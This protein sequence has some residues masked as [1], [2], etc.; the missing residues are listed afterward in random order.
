MKK[1]SRTKKI[2]FKINTFLNNLPKWDGE[3]HILN[4][5]KFI[6]VCEIEG[7][8][9]Q[10]ADEVLRYWFSEFIFNEPNHLNKFKK[11][12]TLVGGPCI[13]K[14]FFCDWLLAE[15]PLDYGH[16]YLD[17]YNTILNISEAIILFVKAFDFTYINQINVRQVWAQAKEN[18]YPF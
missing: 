13:G 12:L 16:Y 8:G 11:K 15:I 6:S 9:K 14:S 18:R 10:D 5:S 2:Y 7:I 3:D 1:K 4:L 17:S